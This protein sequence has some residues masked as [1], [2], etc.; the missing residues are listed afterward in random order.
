MKVDV[1]L[2]KKKI[3]ISILKKHSLYIKINSIQQQI[4]S[5]FLSKIAIQMKTEKGEKIKNLKNQMEI[6]S[7]KTSFQSRANYPKHS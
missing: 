4:K 1:L 6:G 5:T 2:L 7:S 3:K